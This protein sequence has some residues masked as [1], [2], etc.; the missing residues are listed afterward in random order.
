VSSEQR[1]HAKRLAYGLLYGMGPAAL[2]Q[3]LGTDIMT[4]AAFCEEFRKSLPGVDAWLVK[5]RCCAVSLLS[6]PAAL[7]Q[8]C[9]LTRMCA[10]KGP[11][12]PQ[13]CEG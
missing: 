7:L 12:A 1:S 10:D 13:K 11:N 4:A 8:G 2:A 5:V 3:D 6:S 9:V